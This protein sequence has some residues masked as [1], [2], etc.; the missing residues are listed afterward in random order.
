MGDR[1]PGWVVAS[2]A[3]RAPGDHL[4]WPF[5]DRAEL[6]TAVRAFVAEGL[7]MDERV[8]YVAEGRTRDLHDDLAGI[9]DLTGDLEAGRLQL[10]AVEA[11]PA[12]DPAADPVGEL[13]VLA[14]MI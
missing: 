12:S 1:L 11:M 9:A 14:T 5:R 13:P 3:G 6:T 4:C 8:V 2:P 10:L 7:A